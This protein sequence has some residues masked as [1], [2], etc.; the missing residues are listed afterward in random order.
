MIHQHGDNRIIESI[1]QDM[2][3]LFTEEEEEVE[4]EVEEEEIG[5]TDPLTKRQMEGLEE[6]LSV[7]MEEG[8]GEDLISKPL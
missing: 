2:V 4:E 8:M 5:L 7:E 3:T 1:P 6:D